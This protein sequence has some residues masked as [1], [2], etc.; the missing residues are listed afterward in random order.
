MTLGDCLGDCFGDC[1]A[2]DDGRFVRQNGLVP[3]KDDWRLRGG[4]PHDREHFR[5]GPA[6][7]PLRRDRDPASLR[8]CAGAKADRQKPDRHMAD[9]HCAGSIVIAHPARHQDRAEERPGLPARNGRSGAADRPPAAHVPG[10]WR[11]SWHQGVGPAGLDR[12]NRSSGATDRPS[13]DCDCDCRGQGAGSAALDRRS[14]SSG[15]TD[16][17]SGDCDC[18]CRGQVAGDLVAAG[19]S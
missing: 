5:G 9:R 13:G 14:R 4:V 6:A 12:R 7:L 2:G 8:Q 16:R 1:L 17:P 18:D 19:R 15:A 11:G 3:D 10:R